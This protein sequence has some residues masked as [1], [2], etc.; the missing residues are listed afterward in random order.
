MTVDPSDQLLT[1]HDVERLLG[2]TRSTI[3]RYR[4]SG[5]LLAVRLGEGPKAPVRFRLADVRAVL[6]PDRGAV[7]TD[8][9]PR[10]MAEYHAGRPLGGKA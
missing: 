8:W 5:A 9:K 7:P 6:H 2:V 1:Y 4:A 10:T 3:D